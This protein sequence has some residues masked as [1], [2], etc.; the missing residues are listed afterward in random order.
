MTRATSFAR[1]SAVMPIPWPGPGSSLEKKTLRQITQKRRSRHTRGA[2]LNGLADVFARV[3]HISG[4]R[5]G[6][7]RQGRRQ[8]DRALGASHPAG[9]IAV[10]RADANLA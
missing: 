10:G 2:G 1:K 8:I 7:D 9:K 4:E 3:G 6:G 5:A